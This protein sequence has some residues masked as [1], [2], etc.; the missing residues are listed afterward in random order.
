MGLFQ[1]CI[2]DYSLIRMLREKE[3]KIFTGMMVL[4]TIFMAVSAG[5]YH[6]AYWALNI[7]TLLKNS[8]STIRTIVWVMIMYWLHCGD[9]YAIQVS[10]VV[11]C[12]SHLVLDSKYIDDRRSKVRFANLCLAYSQGE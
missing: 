6:I 10:L 3:A 11:C 7:L 8:L 12:Y 5:I 2:I 9:D 1:H 4:F